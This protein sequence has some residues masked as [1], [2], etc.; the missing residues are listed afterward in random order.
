MLRL[1]FSFAAVSVAAFMKFSKLAVVSACYA[2]AMS[3]N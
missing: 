3:P 1:P 2:A